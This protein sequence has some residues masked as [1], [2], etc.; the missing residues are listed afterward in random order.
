MRLVRKRFGIFPRRVKYDRTSGDTTHLSKSTVNK[1]IFF[2][3]LFYFSS[4]NRHELTAKYID[5]L[6][7]HHSFE[8]IALEYSF[9][10]FR[11][12]ADILTLSNGFSTAIEIKSKADSLENLE[13]QVKDYEKCFNYVTVLV[14]KNHEKNV[15]KNISERTG[16]VILD[17]ST[18]KTIRK[19]KLRKRLDKWEL[20]GFF[21]KKRDINLF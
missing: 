20:C 7:E 13:S 8:S 12:K 1:C 9:A 2:E 16:I 11:R 3:L 10:H 18:F 14:D 17:G 5:H 15:R 6:L 19:P 4:M 21:S